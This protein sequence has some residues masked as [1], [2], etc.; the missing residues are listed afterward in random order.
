MIRAQQQQLAQLQAAAG[1]PGHG[2][3]IEDSTPTSERSLSFSL[4]G[5]A[6]APLAPTPSASTPRSPSLALHPRA[7]FDS[8]RRS[9][10]PSQ[11]AAAPAAHLRSASHSH[12][13]Q[14]AWAAHADPARDECAFYQAETNMML[15]ENQILRQRIRELGESP[16][17][18]A[19]RGRR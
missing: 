7:S 15:R 12:E 16:C 5:G 4:G 2:Q 6:G 10:T 17:A 8:G 19:E 3:A 18:S 13:P 1:T 11:G 14:G 9:H